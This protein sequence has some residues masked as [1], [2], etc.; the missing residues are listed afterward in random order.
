MSGKS[1]SGDRDG[2]V[3][4]A[5]GITATSGGETFHDGTRATKA[6][7][8]SRPIQHHLVKPFKPTKGNGGSSDA[9]RARPAP[10]GDDASVD[11]AYGRGK[12]SK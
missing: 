5:L 8:R 7:G 10:E 9:V 1:S 6:P 12:Y 3:R 4:G 2:H 11:W